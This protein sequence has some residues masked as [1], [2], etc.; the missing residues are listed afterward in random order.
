MARGA[1]SPLDSL[2]GGEVRLAVLS[3]VLLALLIVI[4]LG[5]ILLP[6]RRG[7]QAAPRDELRPAL[8]QKES[9][10][11]LLRDFEHDR[12]TGKLDEEEYDAVREEAES[13]AIEAMKRY[14]SLGGADGG[15]AVERAI[16]DEKMKIEKG[17]RT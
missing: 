6:L 9:A 3:W 2:R 8:I 10:L 4:A 16:R 7:R 5:F 11:Q 13:R 15:D 17:A 14:D 12:R 1:W